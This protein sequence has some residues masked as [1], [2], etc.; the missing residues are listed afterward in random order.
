MASQSKVAQGVDI[1]AII[2]D[3]LFGTR[4]KKMITGAILIIIGFLL[5]VRNS[6]GNAS[7]L[8]IKMSEKDK[9]RV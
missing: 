7:N 8:K 3:V 6:N 4:N 9:K 1:K 5:H 2:L